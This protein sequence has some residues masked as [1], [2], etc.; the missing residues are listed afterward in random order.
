[1]NM[2]DKI[3]EWITN[4]ALDV[5]SLIQKHDAMPRFQEMVREWSEAHQREINKQRE[6]KEERRQHFEENVNADPRLKDKKSGP[7]KDDWLWETH[8][9][10]PYQETESGLQRTDKMISAWVPPQLSISAEPEITHL[11]PLTREHELALAEKY[12]ILTA[13]YDYGRKG[14]GKLPPWE[15]PKDWSTPDAMSS[16][17]KC[18]FFENLCTSAAELP[19]SDA[20]WIR[21]ILHDVKSDVTHW[22]DAESP[23]L[24]EKTQSATSETRVDRW[25][26]QAK[27]HPIIAVLIF[28]AVAV[29]GLGIFT[30]SLD[31]IWS[32]VSNR[33]LKQSDS[34]V[35]QQDIMDTTI[36]TATAT[37]DI[38]IA[39]DKAE[40][41]TSHIAPGNYVAFVKGSEALLVMSSTECTSEQTGERALRYYSTVS[42]EATSRTLNQPL[43][44]LKCQGALKPSQYGRVQNQPL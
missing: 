14:T 44:M 3:P 18:I 7:P 33:V 36:L 10:H 4:L 34:T 13:I 23:P 39:S 29:I 42:L 22:R 16:V 11:L 43:S 30:R 37:V 26:N 32:F 35:P 6:W 12:T 28:I 9:F 2:S 17:K 27:N 15:W 25:I 19:E 1:V 41:K 40:G 38:T 21:T 8:V 24:K 20:G 31:D 5:H